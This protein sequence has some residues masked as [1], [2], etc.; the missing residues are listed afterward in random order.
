MFVF[1]GISVLISFSIS[2]SRSVVYRSIN[3]SSS[4]TAAILLA[5]AAFSHAVTVS[6]QDTGLTLLFQNTL[7]V[8]VSCLEDW[9]ELR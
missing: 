2:L 3:M 9:I 4:I 6:N 8:T 1:R 5:L 7:N